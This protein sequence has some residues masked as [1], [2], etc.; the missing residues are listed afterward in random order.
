[1]RFQPDELERFQLCKVDVRDGDGI[2]SIIEEFKPQA[3]IHLA[4]IHYIP[5]CEEKPFEAVS[6]NVMGTVN[7]LTQ[8]PPACRFVLASTAA[9]YK[10]DERAHREDSSQLEPEDVYGFSKLQA[11]QYVRYFAATR[12]FPAVVVRLF[13]V[14]GPGETNPHLWPEIF[15]QLKSGRTELLLG[16]IDSRRDYLHVEDAASG[17][18]AAATRGDIATGDTVTVNIGSGEAHSARQV[19][20]MLRQ[21]PGVE[22]SVT[23]DATRLRRVDRPLLLADR[24]RAEELLAWTPKLDVETALRQMWHAPDLP[25]QLTAKYQL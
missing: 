18:L 25:P 9:V 15:A 10:P 20:E 14:V 19:L 24:G 23:T 16:N 22:F 1:V 21:I 12:E 4:A 6:T 5:E 8:C 11:E 2:R 7:L 3:L 17:F 13:N